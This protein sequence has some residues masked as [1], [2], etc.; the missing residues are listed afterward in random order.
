LVSENYDAKVDDYYIGVD[1]V[2]PV[3]I[4]LPSDTPACGE[5]IVKAQMGAPLG[6]RKITIVPP[7]DSS[8]EIL[9]DGEPS[10]VITVPYG[11]VRLITDGW[12]WWTV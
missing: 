11:S 6:N 2:G 9:I 5:I 1:S 4:T 12:D 7:D 3:T 10:Y 8:S